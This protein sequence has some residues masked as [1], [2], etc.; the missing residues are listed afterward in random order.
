MSFYRE[1]SSLKQILC[2]SNEP[3]STSPGRTQQLLSRLRD[4]QILYFAPPA[5]RRDRSFRQKGQKVRPNVTVYTLP[6]TLFPVSEQ[7]SRLFLRNQRK[8][9]RFIADKAARHCFQSPLLWTTSP[10]QVHLLDHLEYDGLVYDCDRDWEEL[11][12]LWEGALANNADIVFAASPLLADRLSP[13][14]SNIAQ[15]PN[16]VNYPMFSGEGGSI[17]SDP[18][19]QVH[20]PVLGWAGVIHRELDLSPILYAA[21]ERPG[22]TFLL[23][24][25]QEDNPLLP[26]LRRQPNVA[27]AGPCPLNEV[28]DWLFRCDVLLELLREDRPDSDVISGRLYEYLSTGKPIVSMLWPE[29]VEIFPD[30][31]YGAHDEREFLTLCQH[32]L[33]EAPGFVSQRRQSYGAAA[34]W[35]LRAAAVSRILDTAGLL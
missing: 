22:W 11:P 24:G 28:P 31:V 18:L 2:L 25:R 17:Q 29:Q 7:Y 4:T 21:R 8:L 32:A 12:P 26:R 35:S 20:G 15:L 10:E 34:A 30:V 33:E 16:G 1:V 13:C 23:L 6:P 9:G 5:G 19:P 3:W 14:S 27:L